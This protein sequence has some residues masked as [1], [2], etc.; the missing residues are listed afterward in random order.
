MKKRVIKKLISFIFLI[1]L[2]INLLSCSI[3]ENEK[4]IQGKDYDKNFRIGMITDIG[5]IE[6]RGFNQ[7]AWEGL[8]RFTE[9]HPDAAIEFLT[10]KIEDD[11]EINIEYLARHKLDLI[12]GVGFMMADAIREAALE[13]P[14]KRFAIIDDGTY[15]DIPNV[16]CI[17]FRQEEAS[18]LVGLVA[19]LMTKTNNIGYIQGMESD[20]MNLF[21]IGY[22]EGIRAVN[23]NAKIIQR[24]VNTFND[25]E[26]GYNVAIRMIE[27][28]KVDI[29]YHAA[30]ATGLGVIKACKEKGIKAIGV[31]TDQSI[32]APETVLTSA[33]KRVDNAVYR[34]CDELL[35]QK[36]KGGIDE[37]DIEN[38]GVDISPTKNL[39]PDEVIKLVEKKKLDIIDGKIKIP[40]N[41]SMC[42][43]FNIISE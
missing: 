11:Y 42:K 27:N 30:G 36:L 12:I 38:G 33:M 1:T 3:I 19:G 21:D 17:T 10:S 2:V 43:D 20:S 22:I 5:G 28:D 29:I 35:K 18:Y 31:D 39:L 13:M 14:D 7:N 41:K 37:Y 26:K 9:E 6:D 32:V 34:T 23:N 8:K 4:G 15:T 24:N 25:E 16:T 40:K